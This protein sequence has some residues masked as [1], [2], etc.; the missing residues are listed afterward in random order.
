MQSEDSIVL[1]WYSNQPVPTHHLSFHSLTKKSAAQSS[2][3]KNIRLQM[4]EYNFKT[5]AVAPAEKQKV[6][7]LE[8]CLTIN[9]KQ[10]I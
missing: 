7:I 2:V 3:W 4:F 8:D 10:T 9:T 5:P 6:A 1:Q